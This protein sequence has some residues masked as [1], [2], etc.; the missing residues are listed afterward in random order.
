M[1][2][3]ALT[4]LGSHDS[5]SYD[6]DINSSI[7]EPDRLKRFSRIY[8]VR[9]TVRKWATTQVR[10]PYNMLISNLFYM[11]NK[12]QCLTCVGFYDRK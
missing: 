12:G 8:C 6:L 11:K 9:K 1:C 4:F 10:R 3:C 2:M 5:M 7:I